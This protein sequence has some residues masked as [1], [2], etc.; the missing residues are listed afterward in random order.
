MSD[1]NLSV[2]VD[3]SD[4]AASLVYDLDLDQILDLISEIDDSVGDWDFTRRIRDKFDEQI[5]EMEEEEIELD[6]EAGVIP[7]PFNIEDPVKAIHF[8]S[9]RECPY[10]N[11]ENCPRQHNARE[12][13]QKYEEWKTYHA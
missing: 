6:K 3:T 4:L 7:W 2:V 9:E 12:F 13:L 11:V 8:A 5:K 10:S 1:L